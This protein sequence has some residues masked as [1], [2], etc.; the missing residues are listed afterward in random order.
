MLARHRD[1]VPI[2]P[3]EVK[4]KISEADVL[5]AITDWC[6]ANRIFVRRRNVGAVKADYKGR[7]RFIRYGEAGQ[8]DLWLI[9]Q[10]KHVECEV[11]APGKEPTDRQ[12]D[13]MKEVVKAGGCAFYCDSLDDFIYG[14]ND[15][16]KE[17]SHF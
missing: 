6:A 17:V 11:K 16:V 3:R 12:L 7:S 1:G 10:G 4:P 8:S 13:W 2:M 9:Y 5:R 14:L 15:A